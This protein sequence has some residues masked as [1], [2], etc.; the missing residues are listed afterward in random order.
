MLRRRGT[1]G[2]DFSTAGEK[3][4]SVNCM[5]AEITM[6]YLRA[7]V[8]NTLDLLATRLSGLRGTTGGGAFEEVSCLRGTTGGGDFD[9]VSGLRGTTGGGG[10]EESERARAI[11]VSF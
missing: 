4:E 11:P 6:A 7:L 8:S 9:R 3:V 1:S 2:F 5:F 10:L